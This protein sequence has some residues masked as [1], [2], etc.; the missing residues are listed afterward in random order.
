MEK[1][2]LLHLPEYTTRFEVMLIL[3]HHGVAAT[4]GDLLVDSPQPN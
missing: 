1:L 4:L 3:P 2:A